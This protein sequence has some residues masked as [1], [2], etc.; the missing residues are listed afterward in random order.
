M[1]SSKSLWWQQWQWWRGGSGGSGDSGG[2]GSGG[3]GGSGGNLFNLSQALNLREKR[4][5]GC[6]V[7]CCCA[8]DAV[9]DEALVRV[10]DYDA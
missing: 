1:E 3:S 5:C 4:A 2:T 8:P 9:E 10:W 7:D 6:C